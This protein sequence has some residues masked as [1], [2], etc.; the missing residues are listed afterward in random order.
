MS[1][2]FSNVFTKNK[3]IF[4]T[5]L[6][7]GACLLSFYFF[8]TNGL[9]EKITA[10]LVFFLVVPFLYLRFLLGKNLKN[11]GWQIGDWKQ[12]LILAGISLAISLGFFALLFYKT[13]FT[14]SHLLPSMFKDNFFYFLFY[15][16][17]VVNLYLL[18]YELFFRSF[19]MFSFSEKIGILSIFLQFLVF[20]GFVFFSAG[21]TWEYALFIISAFFSG[22]I[23]YRSKS[24]LYALLFSFLFIFLCDV[25]MIKFIVE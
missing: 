18:I 22:I 17:I 7:L 5:I 25:F 3:E 24:L 1:P 16:F 6:L 21:V 13:T 20:L 12:G 19:L 2:Y 8:P 10:L 4:S 14:D 11:Y 9:A 15:E 23:T